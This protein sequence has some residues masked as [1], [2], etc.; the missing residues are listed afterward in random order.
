MREKRKD[1]GVGGEEGG[2]G[3]I[4]HRG[5]GGR[6]VGAGPPPSVGRS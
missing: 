5:V 4:R 3:N 6:K 2:G 1:G